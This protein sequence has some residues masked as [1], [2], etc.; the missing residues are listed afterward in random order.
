MKLP[1]WL[2]F[3]LYP[4]RNSGRRFDLPG[5]QKQLSVAAATPLVTPIGRYPFCNNVGK[6]TGGHGGITFANLPRIFREPAAPPSN[7]ARKSQ[8]GTQFVFPQIDTVNL[9]RRQA[10]TAASG[11]RD[12]TAWTTAYDDL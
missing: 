2:Q 4:Q 6:E 8:S 7:K 1:Q 11:K 3:D 12:A 10:A 9:A 5:Q